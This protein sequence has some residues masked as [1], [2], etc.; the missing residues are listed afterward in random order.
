MN[1]GR[2]LVLVLAVFMIFITVLVVKMFRSAED[3][4]DKD[5]Y[6]KGL[7]YDVEYDQKQQVLTDQVTPNI[8]QNG[9]FVSISFAAVDSGSVQFKRPSNQKLDQYF[10]FTDTLVQIPKSKFEKGEWKLIMHWEAKQK[11][12]LHEHNLFMR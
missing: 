12:Y 4:Y 1:W 7:A 11:K 2:S 8:D 6:E 9:D 10:S 3:S 5:Y